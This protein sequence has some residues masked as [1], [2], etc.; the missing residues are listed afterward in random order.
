MKQLELPEM[1]TP[2]ATVLGGP[3]RHERPGMEGLRWF[4]AP[5]APGKYH[6]N[7]EDRVGIVRALTPSAL[8]EVLTL[9]D[10]ELQRTV[11]QAAERRL[12]K[13]EKEYRH[14]R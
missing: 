9:P 6:C 5:W 1:E 7:V 14:A 13:L 11:R 8:R 4:Q 10:S 2:T 3:K 12:R